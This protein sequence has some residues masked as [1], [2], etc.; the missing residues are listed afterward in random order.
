MLSL[1]PHWDVRQAVIENFD[2]GVSAFQRHAVIAEQ[3]RRN[4]WTLASYTV[5]Q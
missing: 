5:G 4:G 3:L 2:A 1:V